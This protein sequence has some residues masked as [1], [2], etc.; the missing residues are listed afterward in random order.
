MRIL[1][2]ETTGRLGSAAALAGTKH[3]V[4]VVNEMVLPASQ[5]SAQTLLPTVAHVLRPC[6]WRPS[7]I[8]L[9]CVATGPGSFTG[10]R[11]GVTAAKT[12]AF[13]IGAKLVGV[14]SLSALAAGVEDRDRRL[15]AI[16]DAQRQELFTAKF[17]GGDIPREPETRIITVDNWLAELNPGDAVVGPPLAQLAERLPDKVRPVGQQLWQPQASTVGQLGFQL[18]CEGHIVDPI[19]LVPNYYRKSAAEE[20]IEAKDNL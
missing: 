20:K 8:E 11:I 12:L 16:M 17:D 2:L 7:D 14:H 15:W 10:L 1:S 3:G 4:N 6:Q 19:Q 18:F 5:R 9:V 13:A